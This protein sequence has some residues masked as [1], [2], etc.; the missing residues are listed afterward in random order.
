MSHDEIGTQLKTLF[1]TAGRD[2][3]IAMDHPAVLGLQRIIHE[4]W[5]AL[6]LPLQEQI[7]TVELNMCKRVPFSLHLLRLF[8]DDA[9]LDEVFK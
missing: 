8:E 5:D 3:T 7:I 9:D 6:P 4:Q 1:P 2:E